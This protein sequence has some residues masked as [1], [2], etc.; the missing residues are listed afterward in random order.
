MKSGSLPAVEGLVDFVR[1]LDGTDLGAV[2]K[3]SL[4]GVWH[5]S[6][7][8]NE[9]DVSRVAVALGGGGHI[10]AA[11]YTAFGTADEVLAALV[12]ELRAQ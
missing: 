8:S 5:V 12:G 6:L 4:P 10:P 11:G 9:M 7:R 3:E 2:F 1:S